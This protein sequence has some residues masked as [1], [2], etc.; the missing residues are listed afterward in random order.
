M[1]NSIQK[2]YQLSVNMGV[3]YMLYRIYFVLK[4]KSG[5][6][7][8][9]FPVHPKPVQ[10]LSLADWRKNSN[11][12]V[13]SLSESLGRTYDFMPDE[14]LNQK[15]KLGIYKFF[16][17]LE[18]NLGTNYDW[19]TNP[20]TNYKYDV[21]KHW[22]EINDFDPKVGDIKY[23]W[24]KSRFSY[25]YLSIRTDIKNNT[26]SSEYVFSEILSWINA[27]PINQGPNFKCSQEISLRTLNWYYALQFYRDSIYLTEEKFNLIMHYIYWQIKHVYANINFSRIAVRNNHA[28]TETL[29]IYLAGLIFPFFPESTKWKK[30]GKK[31]FEKEIEYQIYADGTFLQFSMNY[32][33]VVIQLLNIAFLITNNFKEKFSDLVYDR[34]YKSLN[35]LYQCQ[36]LENGQL[37]NY[38]A[39]DGALFFPLSSCDYRDYR[40]CLNTL[41]Y[42]LTGNNL[43]TQGPWLEELALFKVHKVE[44][45]FDPIDKKYGWSRFDIG[46]YYILNNYYCLTFIRC[47]NHLDRPSQADNLHIDIWH[48]N[49]N[50]LWDSGSYKYNTS[51]QDIEYFF[52]TESHNTVAIGN[53]SQML[54]GARFIWYYWTQCLV[55][56]T[57]ETENEF[58]FEG[59]ISAFRFLNRNIIH[60]RKIKINKLQPKWEIEDKLINI[61]ES[62]TIRQLWHVNPNYS[63]NILITSDEHVNKITKNGYYSSMYG[64]KME[65][66]YFS[67]E[68]NQ[69]TIS[70]TILL[71]EN[72]TIAPILS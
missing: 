42:L 11:F 19:L 71:D 63:N 8:K 50:V 60:S 20:D 27:N 21:N 53:N 46:G 33:R 24:E 57:T 17:N 16:S 56:Q 47:G 1:I 10:F 13:N 69:K 32:H 25:L 34:A 29:M 54:K 5:F 41:H 18:Y 61:N 52:G 38:G 22:S 70:T 6:F 2:V 62:D 30:N 55:A 4:K 26:D 14:E 39:N 35:F 65:A 64:S 23:V 68:T 37:P 43:Y 59:K 72:S 51:S 15:Q 7:K 48:K 45:N 67:F 66:E 9:E 31:W 58:V 28:I 3:R 12:Y 44:A 49:I 36:N 40:P